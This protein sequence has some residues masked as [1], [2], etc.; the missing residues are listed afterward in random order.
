[1][2]FREGI[3]PYSWKFSF[4]NPLLETLMPLSPSDTRLIALLSEVSK[5]LE[6]RAFTQL[7]EFV[8]ANNL[9]GP[10]Q[11]CYKKGQGTQTTLLGVLEETRLEIEDW[12]LTMIV[13][14]H[15]TKAFDCNS[16]KLLLDKLNKI[17]I[18]CYG[19]IKW[20]SSYLMNRK[21]SVRDENGRPTG[22]RT[23]ALRVS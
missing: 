19:P 6:R 8:E 16:H 21:Q 23:V 9:L 7:S 17:G 22:Y 12:K 11:S 2:Y 20:L 3:F 18:D 4:I 5:I 1:M 13:L 15:F 10:F 14:F